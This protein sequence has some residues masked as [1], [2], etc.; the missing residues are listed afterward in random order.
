MVANTSILSSS[1]VRHIAKETV[2]TRFYGEVVNGLLKALRTK[3]VATDTLIVDH[4]IIKSVVV[5]PN[6]VEVNPENIGNGFVTVSSPWIV[7]PALH[8]ITDAM[9]GDLPG[10][11][12]LGCRIFDGEGSTIPMFGI[13]R[14]DYEGP[15]AAYI[16]GLDRVKA[17]IASLPENIQKIVRDSY[18]MV[19]KGGGAYVSRKW[20]YQPTPE[21]QNKAIWKS[22]FE[23]RKAMMENNILNR[24]IALDHILSG[25][26]V[27]FIFTDELAAQFVSVKYGQMNMS[28]EDIIADRTNRI[29]NM[30]D[31]Q[32]L[33]RAH[34]VVE[35]AQNTASLLGT[36]PVVPE[37]VLKVTHV[38]MM[39]EGGTV[40][41]V[42]I[43]SIP[44][45]TKLERWI[46]GVRKNALQTVGDDLFSRV[47]LGMEAASGVIFKVAK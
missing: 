31:R 26:M 2:N 16:S 34:A 32:V 44:V 10:D 23:G 7:K 8:I 25:K 39:D 6:K 22:T 12:E 24:Q 42:A 37:A 11:M 35:E 21:G 14:A 40:T 41:K 4:P 46:R 1:K 33:A 45:G 13:V 36:A 15:T 29:N 18:F 19:S 28:P 20:E 30:N 43:E 17:G 47:S 38:E 5:G 27:R 9:S 3:G